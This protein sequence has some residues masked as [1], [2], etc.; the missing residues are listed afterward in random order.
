MEHIAIDLGSRQSQVCV[1]DAQGQIL[2]E[3]LESKRVPEVN[4]RMACPGA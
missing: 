2:L 1:R 4:F 3:G